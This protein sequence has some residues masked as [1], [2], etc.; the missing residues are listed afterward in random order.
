MLGVF[1]MFVAKTQKILLSTVCPPR[2]YICR[3]GH[4]SVGAK[5]CFPWYIMH[6]KQGKKC[7]LVL[8]CFEK[9]FWCVIIFLYEKNKQY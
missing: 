8:V 1:Y 5:K 4:V 9:C 3:C 2:G 6:A 7:Q